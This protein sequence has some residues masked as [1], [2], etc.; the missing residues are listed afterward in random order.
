MLSL[1]SYPSGVTHAIAMSELDNEVS[2]TLWGNHSLIP[3][4]TKKEGRPGTH[5]VQIRQ[6]I[7]SDTLRFHNDWLWG[8]GLRDVQLLKCVIRHAFQRS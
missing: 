6:R 8:G 1:Y 7:L 3:M 4:P 2:S 5:C